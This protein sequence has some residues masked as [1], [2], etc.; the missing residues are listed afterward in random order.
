MNSVADTLSINNQGALFLS[1]STTAFTRTP[2]TTGAQVRSQLI[3]RG[4]CSWRSSA[5][6][7]LFTLFRF[8]PVSIIL[9][10]FHMHSFIFHFFIF[11][12]IHSLICAFVYSLIHSLMHLTLTLHN[13]TIDSVVKCSTLSSYFWRILLILIQHKQMSKI[14]CSNSVTLCLYQLHVI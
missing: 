6:A 14:V 1:A 3:S 11:S 7:G 12:F 8:L 4:I 13:L 9:P 2:L 5:R 10:I